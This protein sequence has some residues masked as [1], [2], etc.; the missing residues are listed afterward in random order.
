MTFLTQAARHLVRREAART[1]SRA[2]VRS[3]SALDAYSDYGKHVFTGKV[4][5]EYLSKQG[6]SGDILKDPNWV[7]THAD[8]VAAAVFDW[9]ADE[10]ANVYCHWFQPMASGGVRHG[11]SGQVHNMMLKFDTNG[12]VMKDFK[13]KTLIKGETDG[14]SYP[15]GGLRETHCAGGYLA[16]DTS[17][18]IFLRGD[19]IFIPSV[20]VTYYGAA[21]DEKT[22][23]LRANAALDKE[24]CR[25][26]KHLGLDV[27][28]GIQTNIGLEQEIF[29]IPRDAYYRRPD[30]QLTGRT[31]T[32]AKVVCG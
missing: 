27:S 15:N 22:P 11:L 19:T 28:S 3:F 24:G 20:F 8:T 13:G 21:L 14:S 10:G 25:L 2:G 29:L 23:L 16:I 32:G 31:V 26:M 4:A 7:N 30:L 12:N 9:A 17:S 6:A 1:I 5:E 18:P